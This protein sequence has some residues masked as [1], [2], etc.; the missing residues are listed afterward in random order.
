MLRK[1]IL[2]DII[3]RARKQ[4][5]NAGS[6]EEVLK[7]NELKSLLGEAVEVIERLADQQAMDDDWYKR[8]IEKYKKVLGWKSNR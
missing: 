1:E 6:M 2:D 4:K 8:Y 7:V 5:L 3:E